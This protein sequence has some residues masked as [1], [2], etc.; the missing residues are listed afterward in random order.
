MPHPKHTVLQQVSNP[1]IYDR[2]KD[3]LDYSGRVIHRV[4][5]S[6]PYQVCKEK[7]ETKLCLK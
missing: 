3:M 5:T 7:Y 6:N 1:I 4:Y 2:M